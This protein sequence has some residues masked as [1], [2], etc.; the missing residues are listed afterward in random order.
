M[1]AAGDRV[2]HEADL[3]W[4][5]ENAPDGSALRLRKRLAAAA[6]GREIGAS[7]YRVPA[8]QRPWPRHAHLG[9][10]E[11]IFVLGGAGEIAIGERTIALRTGAYVAIP[12]G[13]TH[14]H[15]IRN[16]GGEDLVFLCVSTMRHPD[17]VVYPDS[18][19]IGVFAGG[20]PGSPPQEQTFRKFVSLAGEVDYWNGE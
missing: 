18:H 16:T 17:V 3:E 2:V 11:A 5:R 13:A 20:A 6:G 1:T 7:L 19:K 10:E 8:G 15:Q 12:A 4:L 9:N 14:A